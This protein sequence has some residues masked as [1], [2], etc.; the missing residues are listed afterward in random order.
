MPIE[1]DDDPDDVLITGV[2]NY[3][4]LVEKELDSLLKRRADEITDWMKANAVWKDITGRARR[5]LKAD[6]EF[7]INE[8]YIKFHYTDTPYQDHLEYGHF[9]YFS[10]LDK[11]LAYW[12]PKLM[13]DV[14]QLLS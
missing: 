7:D 11:T 10:I 5:G 9:G 2:I 3:F 1:W 4:G 14:R 6:L 8:V 12:G 13:D